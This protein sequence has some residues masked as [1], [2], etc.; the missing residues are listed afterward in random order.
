[1]P[2]N[3][4]IALQGRWQTSDVDGNRPAA[5]VAPAHRRLYEEA[6][7]ASSSFQAALAVRAEVQAEVA[8]AESR[9]R[10]SVRAAARRIN[11]TPEK[12]PARHARKCTICNH[13][14]REAIEEEFLHWHPPNGIADRYGLAGDRIVYRHAH[15]VGIYEQRRGKL[16]SALDLIVESA[17]TAKVTADSVIRAI[18]AY[19]CLTPSG[20]WI[21]PPAHVIFSVARPE[22]LNSSVEPLDSNRHP[23]RLE[24]GAND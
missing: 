12:S 14:E 9:E 7:A 6:V 1:M 10:R 20:Q 2:D 8:R 18:R 13:P 21:E 4:S 19:S 17:A 3:E 5:P 15:A 23:R 16:H 11:R 22:P 24:S